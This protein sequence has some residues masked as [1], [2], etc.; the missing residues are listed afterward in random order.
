MISISGFAL[1]VTYVA[2]GL[3]VNLHLSR[4]GITQ[5]QVLKVKYLAV[6]LVYFVN[7]IAIALLASIP[8]FF[9][10]A[11]T[12]LLQRIMLIFS[13]IASVSLLL[14]WGKPRN[15]KSIFFSWRFW[16][17]VG[18]ISSI[19]PLMV[20]LELGITMSLGAVIDSDLVISI[21]LAALAGILSFIGQT[22]YYSGHVYGRRNI[23][24][25]LAADPVGMGIPVRAKL[26]GEKDKISLLSHIGVPMANP[27]TTAKVLLIEETNTHY[28]IALSDQG[29]TLQTVEVSKEIVKAIRYY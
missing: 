7:F 6:G 27:E 20:L 9:L 5:Y 10:I 4:Y 8:S 25:R 15:P 3:I 2:G 12:P 13:L 21:G 11:A 22:Y 1:A 29:D 26:T 18:T 28:L 24:L 19:Y 23:V 17:A 16:V 14:M